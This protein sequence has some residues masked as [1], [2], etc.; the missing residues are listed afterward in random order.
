[1]LRGQNLTQSQTQFCLQPQ[2]HKPCTFCLYHGGPWE[3]RAETMGRNII[4][5]RHWSLR[6]E[7]GWGW[8]LKSRECRHGSGGRGALKSNTSG[9]WGTVWEG[10]PAGRVA[11]HS[12]DK[13]VSR[14]RGGQQRPIIHMP[15]KEQEQLETSNRCSTQAVIGDHAKTGFSELVREPR[16]QCW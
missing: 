3:V 10:G 12:Q 5:Q 8:E 14:G 2:S 16:L 9:T 15:Q 4:T 13:A 7:W 11:R 1:M 6:R